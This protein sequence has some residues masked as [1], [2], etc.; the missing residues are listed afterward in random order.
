MKRIVII[1]TL[2][3]F[4]Q[5][6]AGFSMPAPQTFP[7][8]ATLRRVEVNTKTITALTPGKNYV[9]DLTQRGVVYEFSHQAGAIDFSRVKVRTARGEVA[10]G[11]YLET[12]ILKD[13]L[14]GFKYKSQAFSIAT[15]QPGT[16]KNPSSGTSNFSCNSALCSCSGAR[17]CSDLLF[18]TPLCGGAIFCSKNSA[19]EPICLCV[20]TE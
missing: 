3:V 7:V 12:T 17:D 2:V 13:K 18:N 8:A 16:V 4:A 20:R 19:G 14:A 11:S 9:V 5:I 15:R 1:A 6:A 10:I